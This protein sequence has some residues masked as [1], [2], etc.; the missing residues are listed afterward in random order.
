[1]A[2]VG[3]NVQISEENWLNRN[4]N[5]LF[6]PYWNRSRNQNNG[7]ESES[8]PELCIMES[9]HDSGITGKYDN[10]FSYFGFNMLIV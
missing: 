8:E 7:P 5:P 4:R 1:M 9:V 6:L 2:A 3:Q 10:Y